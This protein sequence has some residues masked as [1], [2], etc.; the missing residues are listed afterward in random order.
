V[1]AV[2][3]KDERCLAA[4]FFIQS[5]RFEDRGMDLFDGRVRVDDFHRGAPAY[6][7][8]H[9][10]SDH[11]GGLRKGWAGGVIHC[12][13]QTAKLLEVGTG[14]TGECLRPIPIGEAGTVRAGD[15]EIRATPF[16]AN[17]C[18][19]AAMFLFESAGG[20]TLVTGDFRLDDA[21]RAVLPSLAGVDLLYVDV[22]YD[23]PR[24][25]FPTQEEVIREIIEFVRASSKELFVIET[26]T[27][28]KNKVLSALYETFREPFYVDPNR[29]RL[30]EALGYGPLI[31]SDPA[32]TRFFACGSR[33]M[34]QNLQQVH[35]GWRRRA[36]VIC[37][38]GWAAGNGR[39]KKTDVGF[40]YSE[41]CSYSELQ[42]FLGA[43][44]PR[45]VVVTEGGKALLRQ[46]SFPG[47]P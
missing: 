18:P 42:E 8:T 1:I 33:F 31:T 24:Y 20:R 47:R 30:Y 40:P 21:M 23:D 45:R 10:H 44:K 43:V 28:G 32:S 12:T 27:I 36:A 39:V 14:V 35:R 34:D 6:F 17:H 9:Y 22:T 25:D 13:P 16:E 37:P 7:L 2:P 11:M 26:Y 29:Y 41:H 46:L 4:L 5:R 15:L 19:G 38:T 3:N